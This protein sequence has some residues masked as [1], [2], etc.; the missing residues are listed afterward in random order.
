MLS[1]TGNAPFGTPGDGS[2]WSDAN[3]WTRGGTV[4]VGVVA[5]DRVVFVAGST[6][7][8]IDLQTVQTVG[9]V[10]FQA[11]YALTGG[12]LKVL[13][14]NIQVNDGIVAKINTGVM[15]ETNNASLR[16]TAPVV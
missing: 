7:Q 3:N 14:G 2:S 1:G 12:S 13:S 9:A 5:K 4:D 6:V 16:K 10:E 15:A 11:N 8:E